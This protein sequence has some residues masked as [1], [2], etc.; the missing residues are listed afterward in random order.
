[1]LLTL[2]STQCTVQEKLEKLVESDISIQINYEGCNNVVFKA[3]ILVQYCFK[4]YILANSAIT[5][6]FK[7]LQA[8]NLNSQHN[9][10]QSVQRIQN[11]VISS[12]IVHN[13]SAQTSFSTFGLS[14]IPRISQVSINVDLQSRYKVVAFLVGSQNQLTISYSTFN[15]SCVYSDNVSSIL[16]IEDSLSLLHVDMYLYYIGQYVSGLVMSSFASTQILLK[17]SNIYGSLNGSV[18]TSQIT[19]FDGTNANIQILSEKIC[20]SMPQNCPSCFFQSM[21]SCC[22]EDAEIIPNNNFYSC[23]CIDP[24]KTEL[25]PQNPISTICVCIE[26]YFAFN[27]QCEKCPTDSIS[28]KNSNI[29]T[30]INNNQVHS[31]NK[32]ECICVPKYSSKINGTCT[33]QFVKSAINQETCY[34]LNGFS[35]VDQ[36]DVSCQCETNKFIFGEMCIQ[37]PQNAYSAINAKQCSCTQEFQVHITENNQCECQPTY[38]SK[39]ANGSCSCPAGATISSSTCTCINGYNMQGNPASCS[40]GLNYFVNDLQCIACPVDANSTTLNSTDCTCIQEYQIHNI[41]SN[42]CSCTPLYSR[43]LSSGI[44]ACQL[45]GMSA[46]NKDTCYCLNGFSLVAGYDII[47]T[48]EANKYINNSICISCP[49]DAFSSINASLCTCAKEYQIH[50]KY[51]NQCECQPTYST[52]QVDGTCVCPAGATISS[53]TCTCI[54]GY[55]MQGNPASCSCGQN[56]FLNNSQCIACPKD[57]YSTTINSS[58]CTCNY[59]NQHHDKVSNSCVCTP[60]YSSKLVA[61]GVCTCFDGAIIQGNTC[62]CINNFLLNTAK[63]YSCYCSSNFRSGDNGEFCVRSGSD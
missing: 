7:F 6:N 33:C 48:C 60:L 45:S 57:A 49:I 56:Y 61:T 4:Q 12:S 19:A 13:Q 22:R 50:N 28:Q 27:M 31:V 10:F 15:F 29:C 8:V 36:Q 1:M 38:S 51:S 54:N 14:S 18:L 25:N 41:Q 2:L 40:C 42:L 30:C 39:L 20:I 58:V 16:T 23:A 3:N 62:F 46:I 34:C 37:C 32:N 59:A 47:C 26:N 11:I 43:K 44:C 5:K 17:L 55:N 63:P 9:V 52:K 53:S 21:T 24:F 35:L